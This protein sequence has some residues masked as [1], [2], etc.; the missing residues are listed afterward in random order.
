MKA[1]PKR[2]PRKGKATS[3]QATSRPLHAGRTSRSVRWAARYLYPMTAT[4]LIW[5]PLLRAGAFGALH[6]GHSGDPSLGLSVLARTPAELE[7]ALTGLGQVKATLLVAPEMAQTVP[8]LLRGAT[9]LGHEVAGWGDPAGLT[10]LE[11]A[12]GQ[13]VQFWGLAQADLQGPTLRRLWEQGL[14]LLPMQRGEIE[15]GGIL[16]LEASELAA[17]LPDLRARGYKPRPVRDLPDLR[18]ATPRDLFGAV[19]Q[20]VVEDRY[21]EREGIIDLSSRFDAVMRV[22]PLDHAPD[23]LPL[24]KGTPT[25]ELHLNSGRLVGLASKQWLGTYRAYQRSLKDVAQALKIHPQLQDAQAVFAVTLFHGPLEK[26]GFTLLE[27]PP[28]R[29]QWYGLGFRLLRL[30][31]GTTRASSESVPKMAWM[32]REDFLAKYG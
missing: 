14:P 26:S 18:A 31:Y 24:P 20:K 1:E 6:G 16:R 23:P 2:R 22:A 8:E 28:L 27:L 19:Y 30:A 12:A 32:S 3:A 17:L 29:A 5:S 15:P 10:G 9:R 21:A 13:A 25:A 11:V 4:S 7:A